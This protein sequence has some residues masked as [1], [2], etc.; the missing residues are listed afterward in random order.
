[1]APIDAQ[2][3]PACLPSGRSWKEPNEA[4]LAGEYQSRQKRSCAEIWRPVAM[5]E[6]TSEQIECE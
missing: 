6:G 4:R 1:M 2:D 5:A 3:P